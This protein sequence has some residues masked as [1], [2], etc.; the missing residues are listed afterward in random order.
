M[1]QLQKL[2]IFYVI[3]ISSFFFFLLYFIFSIKRKWYQCLE[4]LSH[5][6]TTISLYNLGQFILLLSGC[7]YTNLEII[8]Y[9]FHQFFFFRS[10][11]WRSITRFLLDKRQC[12]LTMIILS[13]RVSNEFTRQTIVEYHQTQRFLKRETIVI[14]WN[15]S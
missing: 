2:L 5:I 6:S 12:F 10:L 13:E 4:C 15:I 14:Y 8:M 9:S 1:K 11:K 7:K 3:L